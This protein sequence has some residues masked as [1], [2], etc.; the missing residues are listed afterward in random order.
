MLK[1]NAGSL[2][3]SAAI[4]AGGS[5]YLDAEVRQLGNRVATAV[6]GPQGWQG[7]GFQAFQQSFL[8]DLGRLQ[9]AANSLREMAHVLNFLATRLEAIDQ[10]RHQSSALKAEAAALAHR[11]PNPLILGEMA[12]LEARAESLSIQADIEAELADLQGSSALS[13]IVLSW[14][15]TPPRQPFWANWV[16]SCGNFL[17]TTFHNGSAIALSIWHHPGQALSGAASSLSQALSLGLAHPPQPP[18]PSLAYDAGRFGGDIGSMFL[19]GMETI[20]GGQI[21]AAGGVMTGGGGA[22]AVA[23]SETGVAIPVGAAI[24]GEGLVV[25]G[26]GVAMAGQGIGAVASGAGHAGQDWNNM[27]AK[28]QD[29]KPARPSW[30][31]SENDVGSS[32]PDYTPQKSFKNG[33]E[34]PYGTSGSS[35]PDFYKVGTSLEVKNYDVSTASGRSRLIS[36]IVGQVEK[37]MG[38]LPG[39]T[40]QTIIIDVRQ[41]S[42]SNSV[43]Q[44][45]RDRIVA[46]VGNTVKIKF[47]R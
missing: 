16:H 8:N 24:S 22:L 28:A 35:R 42:V 46:Q 6:Y 12:L 14:A 37:R 43:L 17:S 25:I 32:H 10:L 47:M 38:D 5:A 30:R 20:T 29:T 18:N 41:Q 4:I 23:G 45:I 21:A 2:R 44:D 7:L 36:T 13:A 3:Q 39:G 34:V 40:Q 9:R 11:L 31:Q 15:G 26:A 19:G 1:G 27:M 33:E